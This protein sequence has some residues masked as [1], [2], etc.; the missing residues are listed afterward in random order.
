MTTYLR[1]NTK[2]VGHAREITHVYGV[3]RNEL[4]KEAHDDDLI[5]TSATS[6]PWNR[7]CT[8]DPWNSARNRRLIEPTHRARVK[9][10]ALDRHSSALGFVTGPR[11]IRAVDNP[12]N[13]R[14]IRCARVCTG[15]FGASGLVSAVGG[16]GHDRQLAALSI[17]ESG[18]L[19]RRESDR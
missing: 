8:F 10:Y 19:R 3:R 7:Q 11:P 9:L 12:G 13:H 14:V 4:T 17:Q 15:C 2:K 18:A 5:E 16:A 1:I 6:E